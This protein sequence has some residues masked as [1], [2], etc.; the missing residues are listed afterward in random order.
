[1]LVNK[2][3]FND[4]AFNINLCKRLNEQLILTLKQKPLIE[5]EKCVLPSECQ[6]IN[7]NCP[8]VLGFKEHECYSPRTS[9]LQIH[10]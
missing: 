9:K 4:L 6:N 5:K 2:D 3:I 1:M 8:I 7:C 10:I